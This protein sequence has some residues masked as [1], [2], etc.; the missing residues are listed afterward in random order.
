M[1]FLQTILEQLTQGSSKPILQEIKDGQLVSTSCDELL[2]NVTRARRF[3]GQAGLAR[4]DRCALLASNSSRWVALDLAIMAEGG[5][6]VPLYSRQSPQELVTILKDCSPRW[7]CCS[8]PTL[9]EGVIS[10]WKEAPP[11]LLFDQILGDNS[12]RPLR[13]AAVLHARRM[14]LFSDAAAL[15]LSELPDDASIALI[16]TSGTSGEPKGVLLTVRNVS[17]MLEQ[18]RRRLDELMHDVPKE[19]DDRVFHYLPFC[20][21]GSWILLLTCLSR[22]NCLMMSMDLGK[23]AEELKVADPHYYLNV[24]A[25]LERMRRA[26]TSQ[27]RE[28]GRLALRLFEHGHTACWRSHNRKA[29][30]LDG[31]WCALAR[32]FVFPKIRKRLGNNLRA[33]ICGSAPLAEETQLFFQMLGISVLQ[34]YGLTETTAICT[35]DAVDHVTPGR[36]GPAIPGIEMKLGDGD[37]ILVRG[38]NVFPGYWN[39]PAATAEMIQ[40]GWLHTGDQGEVDSQGNWRITGRLKNLIITSG[41]H[42][43]SPEPIEQMILSG[44]PEA[45]QVMVMGN[46]R[47]FLVVIIS[48]NVGADRVGAVLKQVNQQLPHYKQVRRFFAGAGL[49]SEENG[50][51]TANRKLRRE[52]IEWRYRNDIEKLYTD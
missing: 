17:F 13:G 49:L 47:K 34:V 14:A 52:M 8:D 5:I 25:M 29:K 35:M 44:L 31:V 27:V 10:N 36:V 9:A 46:E 19:D 33:L 42:N 12:A 15:F 39:R 28:R 18:T 48:G 38:P 24:P 2:D 45:E 32:F 3:F 1:S 37:E 22:G 16:Y 50:L 20:F 6:A 4:G 51:V 40:D 23:L 30:L 41:G 43:V 11:V 7:L 21:A 26:I